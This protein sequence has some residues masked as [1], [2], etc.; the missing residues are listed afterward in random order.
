VP[1]NQFA[2][3]AGE[4]KGAALKSSDFHGLGH[5]IRDLVKSAVIEVAA[6]ARAAGTDPE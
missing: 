3:I 2:C 6:A 1:N 5:S 4:E